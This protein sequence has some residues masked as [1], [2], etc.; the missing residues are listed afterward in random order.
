MYSNRA[1]ILLLR[2]AEGV[3]A[4]GAALLR[5][6]VHLRKQNRNTN[7]P[8]VRMLANMVCQKGPEMV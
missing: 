5:V 4:A 7:G 2:L 1:T 6:R 8:F 3:L